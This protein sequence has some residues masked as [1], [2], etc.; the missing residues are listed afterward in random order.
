ME[1]I[2]QPAGIFA[3]PFMLNIDDQTLREG[4]DRAADLFKLQRLS[5]HDD[6][7]VLAASVYANFGLDEG[8]RLELIESLID[9]LPISGD[10]LAE[11]LMASAMS[12]GVLV[13]L[14]IAHAGLGADPDALPDY[15]PADF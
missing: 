4:L 12:A 5:T 3:D 7:E 6:A 15:V 1:R 2:E 13:G 8:R 9:M 11:G 10:P 14:L